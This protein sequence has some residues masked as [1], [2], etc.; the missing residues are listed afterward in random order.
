VRRTWKKGSLTGNTEGYITVGSGNG[1]L[2]SK[3]PI[4]RPWRENC[5]AVAL[6]EKWDFILSGDF[7]Y[8][9]IPAIRKRR[10]WKRAALSIGAPLGNLDEGS[11]C[12]GLWETDKGGSENGASLSMGALWGFMQGGLL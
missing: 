3:G 8:W 7:I 11:F 1:Y 5:F 10:F 9:G 6:R 4:G 12:R 2:S